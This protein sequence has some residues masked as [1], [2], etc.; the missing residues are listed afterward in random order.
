MKKNGK[1]ICV[2]AAQVPFVRGGA[3]IM[4]D[5]L[6]GALR[7]RG[8]DVEKVA[9]P[10]KWYPYDT[11]KD[12]MLAWRMLDL[13]ETNGMDIDLVIGTKFPSYGARHTNKV[14]WLIHQYRQAYD[15][16]ETDYSDLGSNERGIALKK[17]VMDFDEIT[18]G[19]AS[20]LYAISNNVR[21]RLKRYNALQAETLYHPP[22]NADALHCTGYGDYILSVGRMDPLKRL[23]LLIHALRYCPKGIKAYIAGRGPQ[24]Q[25]LLKLAKTLGVMDRVRFLGY[26]DD[27]ALRAL[28]ADAFAVYYAPLDEDYGYVALEA[29]Y[30]QKPVVTCYDAGGV[31]EFVTDGVNGCVTQTEPEAIGA[32]IAK[33]W[34]DKALC[35]T[36]GRS[37]KNRVSAIS[38]DN[39][40]STLT[41]T[42]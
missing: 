30:A 33:L 10:Y 36:Y 37:G 16:L 40:V 39:V 6:I 1:K 21:D 4:V 15:L 31:L 34:S 18:L 19:E 17:Q 27:D 9:L 2:L 29:F 32:A 22:N 28:Y 41:Q 5:N 38:W 26:V 13:S 35:Q 20:G 24:T 7:H 42:I 3:E 8:F 25:M 14:V 23:D 11:L 12:N